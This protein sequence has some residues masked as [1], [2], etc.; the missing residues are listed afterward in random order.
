VV[1]FGSALDAHFSVGADLR[2][3]SDMDEEGMR[4]RVDACH[5]LV[6]RMR[7]SPKPVRARVRRGRDD[8]GHVMSTATFN[9]PGREAT[10]ALNAAC[11]SVTGWTWV[12]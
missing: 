12:T 3:F 9:C 7:G 1:V 6:R 4:H 11:T 10:A 8:R 2:V 5:D